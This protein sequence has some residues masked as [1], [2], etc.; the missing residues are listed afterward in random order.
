M[1]MGD[2]TKTN[3]MQMAARD[4]ELILEQLL[5]ISK[6]KKTINKLRQSRLL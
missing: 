1:S 2:D 6:L 5:E 4:Q 3:W